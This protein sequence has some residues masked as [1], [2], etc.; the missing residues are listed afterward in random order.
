MTESPPSSPF[1]RAM[2]GAAVLAMVLVASAAVAEVGEEQPDGIRASQWILRPSIT[3]GVTY[4]SNPFFQSESRNPQSD[5]I[6]VVRPRIEA[7]LPFSNSYWSIDYAYGQYDFENADLP[8]DS[9]QEMGTALSLLFGSY[10]R[11]SLGYRRTAGLAR[12]ILYDEGGEAVSDGNTFTLDL[13]EASLSRDVIGQRGYAV[14]LQRRD[15]RFDEG[16]PA[17][18]FNYLGWDWSVEYRE[19][20]SPVRWFTVS[21][22][23][24]DYD[25]FLVDDPSGERYRAEDSQAVY[26]GITERVG[27][28]RSYRLR[29][30]YGRSQFPEGLGSEFEGVVGDG[31]F[32][33]GIGRR[34]TILITASRAPYPSYYA[35]NNYFVSNQL[36]IRL[37]RFWWPK[38]ETGLSVG[39]SRNEY[40]D[41]LD[42]P[43]DPQNG[44]LRVDNLM[45]VEVYAN[46][47]IRNTLG[48]RVEIRHLTRDSNYLGAD[49]NVTNANAGV[50][51]GW[52]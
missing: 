20:L 44:I 49:Y 7:I 2:I 38:V 31:T 37:Q 39:A 36:R 3:S 28:R 27:R 23:G 16:A 22:G 50:T 17:Q 12:S 48:F 13:Y 25:H 14:E 24:R 51:I 33:L 19:P 34:T 21:L 35:N 40:G 11:L 5:R 18:F 41:P 30:G 47:V 1:L 8:D 46:F 10:E 4:S 45:D 32:S 43:G 15:F 29:I 9:T 26:I 42:S 52:L 6:L